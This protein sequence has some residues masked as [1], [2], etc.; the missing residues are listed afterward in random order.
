M[1]YNITK[2]TKDQAKKLGVVVKVSKVITNLISNI[3]DLIL[4]ICGLVFNICELIFEHFT[5]NIQQIENS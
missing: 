1:G 4:N 3:C 5:N 2:Y